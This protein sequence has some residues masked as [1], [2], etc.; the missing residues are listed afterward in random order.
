MKRPAGIRPTRLRQAD[1]IGEALGAIVARPARAAGTSL[2]IGACAAWFV[3]ALGLVSTAAG[4]VTMA[5]SHRLATQVWVTPA[6]HGPAPATGQFAASPFPAGSVRRLLA[7]RGV[8]AAGL[9]WPVTAA[10]P[11]P[12]IAATPGFLR[13]AGVRIAQGRPFGQWAQGH[14]A[15]VCVA[16][17]A[18]AAQ[19]GLT[20]LSRQPS[21]TIGNESCTVIGIFDATSKQPGLLRSVLIPAATATALFG[22]PAP[23]PGAPATMLIRT[24]PGAAQVVAGQA[25]YAIS[26]ARPGQFSVMV[27]PGP[28]RLGSQ[29]TAAL[30]GLFA[31]LGW[32]GLG[33][34]VCSLALVTWLSAAGRSPEYAL[35]RALGA[36][37]RHVV[38][39]I[40]WECA[41]LG[42]LGGL[43]GTSLGV[44]AVVLIAH[45]SRWQPVI[46]PLTVFPAPIAGAAAAVLAGLIPAV[47]ATSRQPAIVLRG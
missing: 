26:A 8:L 9:S 27:P 33:I 39:H 18:A 40:G 7:L 41:I 11:V 15:Q 44:A 23:Q 47:A 42:L 32:T 43:A 22:P 35:R 6:G 10:A 30:A 25:P 28:R 34:A 24:R 16:G 3:I 19:L 13:A 29:L 4:Q 31:A 2:A 12:V 5:V 46:A 20:G 17:S 14:A 1:A 45:A 21:I 38:A 36:R 37:R